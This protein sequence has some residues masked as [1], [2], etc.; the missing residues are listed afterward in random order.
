MVAQCVGAILV[1]ADTLLLGRRAPHRKSYPN[2]WDIIG[3]HVEVGETLEQTLVREAEEEIGVTP[4]DFAK[5]TSLQFAD[6]SGGASVL[7]IYRVD[8]WSG[9]IPAIRDDEHSDLRW[10]TVE[11]V[12]DLPDLASTEYRTVFRAIDRLRLRPRM[13]RRQRR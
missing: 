9:G 2:F 7:H 6:G 1:K 8:A 4:V 13:K 5:L 12:C 11:A 3:G 10:F